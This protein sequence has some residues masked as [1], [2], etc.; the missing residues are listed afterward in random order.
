MSSLKSCS[1][2]K[3]VSFPLRTTI[4]DLSGYYDKINQPTP[5]I[6]ATFGEPRRSNPEFLDSSRVSG[7]INESR[8]SMK[9]KYKDVDYILLSV[10]LCLATHTDWLVDP[11]IKT[12]NKIDIII[13]L[14]N[15]S[16]VEPRFLI[17]TI[18]LINDKTITYDNKYLQGLA[19]LSETNFYSVQSL[20]VGLKDYFFY[21]T[22]FEPH[23]DNAFVY[24]NTDGLKISETMYTSLLAIWTN[25]D[26]SDIQKKV[27][28]N[29]APMKKTIASYLDKIKTST[30]ITQIQMQLQNVQTATQAP[31]L[32]PAVDTWPRYSP[33]YDVLLS[34]P[35][36]II[37][38]TKTME[39]FTSESSTSYGATTTPLV[40]KDI[41][42]PNDTKKTDQTTTTPAPAPIKPTKLSLTNL[43]CIPLDLDSYDSSGNINFD[44][45]GNL[46]LS[47]IQEKRYALRNSSEISVSKMTDMLKYFAWTIV[48]L[49]GAVLLHIAYLKIRQQV[50]GTS[51]MLPSNSS[52]YGLY[53]IILLMVGFTGFVIGAAI[54]PTTV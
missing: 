46:R 27:A 4:Y 19:Y 10:Q 41:V 30:D 31:S 15:E 25:Q 7:A 37:T 24:V 11:S 29:V 50:S 8:T 9:M 42:D 43:K 51:S 18:P 39:G 13:T 40:D 45:D 3:H 23:G 32:N 20:F 1:A 33:P 22:C 47:E 2:A 12:Q 14:E 26:L 6:S 17:T 28:D 53:G 44:T 49:I 34:I 35:G 21:T 54:Q 5:N 16:N 36:K 38:S 52:H 48:A